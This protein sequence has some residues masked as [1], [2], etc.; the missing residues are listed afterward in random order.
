MSDRS[1][2]G[3]RA[4]ARQVAAA[5]AAAGDLLHARQARP[6]LPRPTLSVGNLAFGGRGKTPLVAALAARATAAGVRCAVL[7]RGA[8]RRGSNAIVA[9]CEA[10]TERSWRATVALDGVPTPAPKAA[11]SAGEEPVWLATQVPGM[12]VAVHADRA[13]AAAALDLGGIDLLLLDDGFQTPIERDIDLVLLGPGDRAGAWLRESPAALARA[14]FVLR[15]GQPGDPARSLRDV[16]ALAGGAPPPGTLAAVCGVGDPGSVVRLA[17]Q[18][19]LRIAARPFVLDHRPPGPRVRRRHAG[20]PWLVTEKDALRWA[21][22]RPPPQGAWVI[23][24]QLSGIDD[25]WDRLAPRVSA[26]VGP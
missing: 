12:P 26:L 10:P 2:S 24:Q 11:R 7:T 1:S 4:A 3:G 9:C 25:L 20:L 5:I 14:D 18:A 17:E 6:R 16:V 21:A 15:L 19:G 22:L 13:Q 8:G 23:R